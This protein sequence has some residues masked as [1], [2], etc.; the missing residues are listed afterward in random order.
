MGKQVLQKDNM[1]EAP[2]L[3]DRGLTGQSQQ[4]D[5]QDPPEVP[6]NFPGRG[7]E[8]LG[9]LL[10]PGDCGNLVFTITVQ[11][12]RLVSV[13][14]CVLFFFVIVTIVVICERAVCTIFQLSGKSH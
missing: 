5:G 10:G 13:A 4:A 8:L 2:S 11:S 1:S 7:L 14:G 6:E 12:P 3:P 9:Q